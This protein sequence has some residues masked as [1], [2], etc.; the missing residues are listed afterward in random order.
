MR[1]AS[2]TRRLAA[3]A[4]ALGASACNF[5]P[6]NASADAR[7][8]QRHVMSEEELVAA[9]AERPEPAAPRPQVTLAAATDTNVQQ[10][11]PDKPAEADERADDGVPAPKDLPSFEGFGNQDGDDEGGDVSGL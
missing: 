2:F 4:L 5:L 7:H 3:A 8:V 9:N 6:D 11:A 10:A 1:A